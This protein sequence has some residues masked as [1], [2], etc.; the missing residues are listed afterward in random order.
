MFNSTNYID[1]EITFTIILRIP[2]IKMCV[3]IRYQHHCHHKS[4]HLQSPCSYAN[5]PSS[6]GR[7]NIFSRKWVGSLCNN[8]QT[9]KMSNE[10]G[11]IQHWMQ[12][13][14]VKEPDMEHVQLDEDEVDDF[15][16]SSM[17]SSRRGSEES[18]TGKLWGIDNRRLSRIYFYLFTSTSPFC[19]H[20]GYLFSCFCSKSSRLTTLQSW[21]CIQ[22]EYT[23]TWG[24]FL[25]YPYTNGQV[26]TFKLFSTFSYTLLEILSVC[27]RY[28]LSQNCLDF[29]VITTCCWVLW[30]APRNFIL[31]VILINNDASCRH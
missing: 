9:K 1:V 12:D 7:M 3:Y 16:L 17:N 24:V 28:D 22:Y 8:C 4:L 19:R 10:R 30:L 15:R 31:V 18:H 13:V 23:Q 6:C 5:S 25:A 11:R 14:Q 21:C 2:S 20:N 27:R 29:L 26:F